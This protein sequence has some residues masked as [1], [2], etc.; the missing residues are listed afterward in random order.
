MKKRLF[1]LMM[2][3]ISSISAVLSFGLSSDDSFATTSA[4]IT[5]KEPISD[6]AAS[7]HSYLLQPDNAHVPDRVVTDISNETGLIGF[8][9]GVTPTGAKTYQIPID[10]CP[11]M[12]GFTPELSL[13]YNSQHG[14]SVL[15]TGWSISGLPVISRSNR[16]IYYDGVAKGIAMDSMMPLCLTGSV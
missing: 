5:N 6:S 13:V 16:N 2:M 14:N 15:G 8:T 12:N 1:L 11:G 9:S 3:L 4:D 7:S 10:V